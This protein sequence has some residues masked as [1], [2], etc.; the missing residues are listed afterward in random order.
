MDESYEDELWIL[1]PFIQ[2]FEFCSHHTI[3][4]TKL[5]GISRI[6]NDLGPK[7]VPSSHYL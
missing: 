6:N 5:P 4:S 1:I 2:T 7:K 3:D